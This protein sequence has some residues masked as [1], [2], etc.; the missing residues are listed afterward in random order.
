MKNPKSGIV[1]AG[2]NMSVLHLF[3]ICF[4]TIN[5]AYAQCEKEASKWFNDRLLQKDM[6]LSPHRSINE[7]EFK[8]QY[9]LNPRWWDKAFR[10]IK[11]HNLDTLKVGKYVIEEDNVIAFVSEGPSKEIDQIQWETHKNF[12]DL[13][14]IIA[15]KAK[16]GMAPL[17]NSE[18]TISTPYN[19]QKDVANYE[20]VRGNYFIGKPGYYFIFSPLDIH[21]PA[22]KIQKHSTIKRLLIKVRVPQA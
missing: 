19:P 21:R 14:Y 20:D 7:K 18:F 22:I 12:N 3:L 5:L 11:S 15:G 16:M 1:L 4:A 17:L 13:Q 9:C 10:F 8:R 6:S 2:I